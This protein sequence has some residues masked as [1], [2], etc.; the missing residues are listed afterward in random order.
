MFAGGGEEVQRGVNVC[1]VEDVAVGEASP[2]AAA[3]F[4]RLLNRGSAPITEIAARPQGG[5]KWAVN[6]LR[7]G[8]IPPG[9]DLRLD[10]PPGGQC[11]FDL[12]VTFE[13]GRSPEKLGADLCKSPDQA[14]Q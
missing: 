5:E 12:R 6:R 4:F 8:P 14:V 7:T 1:K 2:V 11:V 13:G 9:G 3:K 10:L